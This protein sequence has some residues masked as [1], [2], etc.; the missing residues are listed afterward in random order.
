[1]APPASAF[2][3]TGSPRRPASGQTAPPP[4]R[5]RR[6]RRPRLHPSRPGT[7]AAARQT[8]PGGLPPPA[9]SPSSTPPGTPSTTSFARNS[10]PCRAIFAA[11][12][13]LAPLQ[14]ERT[15]TKGGPDGEQALADPLTFYDTSSY[16]PRA[17]RAM[18]TAVGIGQ[19]VHGTDYPV[20]SQTD[21]PVEQAFGTGLR[22][23]R[24]DHRP[25][26]RPRLHLGARGQRGLGVTELPSPISKSTSRPGPTSPTPG[27]PSNPPRRPRAHLRAP[28]PR[29]PRRDLPRLLDARSRHRL[30]RPRRQRRR[31]RRPRRRDHRGAPLARERARRANAGN[32]RHPSPSPARPS[33]A[34]RHAGQMPAT[35]LHAYSPPLQ[36]VGTYQVADDGALLRHP[37][38]AETPLEAAA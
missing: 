30:P 36:R 1:M 35:T 16:G 4:Q 24:Q 31:D 37:R 32:R 19:L 34:S 15:T 14:A 28:P 21:D 18:A 2:P 17:V 38:P 33:T 8:P 22:P 23:A 3:P 25:R 27:S 13:G 11:L 6:H 7:K 12:A 29:R 26:P 10:P 20:H 5:R 9:T